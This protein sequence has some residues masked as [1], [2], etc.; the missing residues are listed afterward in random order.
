MFLSCTLLCSTG[1]DPALPFFATLKPDWKLDSTDAEFVDI[2]HTN[3]GIY[4]KVEATGHTD[5]YVNGGTFQPRCA[6]HKS[7]FSH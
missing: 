5:F 7:M 1:L 6:N 4:G 3:S 2:I